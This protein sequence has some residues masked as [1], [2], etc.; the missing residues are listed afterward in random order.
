MN[1]ACGAAATALTLLHVAMNPVET[2]EELVF[3]CRNILPL[4]A[5][6]GAGIEPPLNP[7]PL[8]NGMPF[9]SAPSNTFRVSP[10]SIPNALKFNVTDVAQGSTRKLQF[11]E[12]K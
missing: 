5:V 8:C 9:S 2:A 3:I 1:D 6:T 4:C 7:L 10:L 11:S 12:L